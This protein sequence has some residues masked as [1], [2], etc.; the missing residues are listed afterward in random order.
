MKNQLEITVAKNIRKYR[1]MAHLSQSD[2]A[3]KVERTPEMI[4]KIENNKAGITCDMISQI[5]D[6]FQ[7]PPY[8]LVLPDNLLM[9][10]VPANIQ[11][12]IQILQNQSPDKTDLLIMIAHTWNA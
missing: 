11:K 6:V 2:L 10:E 7:I 9:N 4:C 3:E 5:A 1:K 8:Y 12:L